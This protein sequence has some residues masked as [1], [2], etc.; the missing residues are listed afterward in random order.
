MNAGESAWRE[1]LSFALESWAASTHEL[2]IED[3]YKWLYQ[4]ALGPEHAVVDRDS[5]RRRLDIE[6]DGLDLRD[7][8]E[9]LWT[10]L[11]VAGSLGRLNLRPF[12]AA[13]GSIDHL[14]DAFVQTAA[15]YSGDHELLLDT[16]KQFGILLRE[17]GPLGSIGCD[18]WERLDAELHERGYPAIHHSPEYRKAAAPAY[19][20]LLS[21]LCPKS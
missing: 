8:S 17:R 15:R 7:A 3:T 12:K 18:D 13:G 11:N 19:R 1:L 16:W 2:R 14:V 10:P 4:A 5:A 6:F 20:V 9:P 21:E